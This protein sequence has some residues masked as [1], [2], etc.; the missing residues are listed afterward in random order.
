M[1]G[2]NGD[3][4]VYGDVKD[5]RREMRKGFDDFDE[6]WNSLY[7]MLAVCALTVLGSGLGVV[8]TLLTTSGQ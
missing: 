1:F 8:V 6:K 4:G 5:M 2:F 3:N 7:K